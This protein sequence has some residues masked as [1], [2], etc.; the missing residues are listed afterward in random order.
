VK[1]LVNKIAKNLHFFILLYGAWL[2]FEKYG[3]HQTRVEEIETRFPEVAQ[4][5]MKMEK[6]FLR[7]KSLKNA[8]KNRSLEFK[9]LR[10]IF[11][12]LNEDF[13]RPSTITRFLPILTRK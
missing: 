6:R 11:L 9:K 4:N 3:E 1:D 7:F 2:V 13:R 5:I 12:K 10:K 8:V